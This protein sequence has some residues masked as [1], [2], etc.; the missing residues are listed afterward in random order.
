MLIVVHSALARPPECP[1]VCQRRSGFPYLGFPHHRHRAGQREK[2]RTSNGAPGHPLY[3]APCPRF[4]ATPR[5]PRGQ[6]VAIIIA[7]GAAPS[8][9]VASVSL[10]A[11][12]R[13]RPR[14]PRSPRPQRQAFIRRARRGAPYRAA[15]PRASTAETASGSA[16]TRDRVAARARALNP[17]SSAAHCV[18]LRGIPR[19]PMLWTCAPRL[20][21][22]R[23]D[24]IRKNAL[25]PRA[26]AGARCVRPHMTPST[27]RDRASMPRCARAP[28]PGHG[29]RVTDLAVHSGRSISLPQCTTQGSRARRA[30]INSRHRALAT[31]CRRG[32]TRHH[33]TGLRVRCLAASLVAL[34]PVLMR[35]PPASARCAR[36]PMQVDGPACGTS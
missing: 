24:L 14:A 13:P 32:W 29:L 19:P 8:A 4:P 7:S 21:P 1:V 12:R 27:A 25:P 36:K 10:R 11:P 33:R 18:G 35:A 31:S 6:H 17:L 2:L 3:G 26:Q 23:G 16:S 30:P 22:V 20:P 9:R 28:Y 34:D 15:A 5:F